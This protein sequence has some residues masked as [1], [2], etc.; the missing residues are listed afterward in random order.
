[1][2]HYE[3]G[4]VVRYGLNRGQLTEVRSKYFVYIL[5]MNGMNID[6]KICI[7]F[8]GYLLGGQEVWCESTGNWRLHQ[9]SRV[10]GRTTVTPKTEQIWSDTLKR[11][12]KHVPKFYYN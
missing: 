4:M 9:E 12:V 6:I 1:M 3:L 11:F 10:L 8:Y 2:P 7:S 5:Y